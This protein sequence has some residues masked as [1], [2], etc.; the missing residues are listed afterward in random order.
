[1]PTAGERR[2]TSTKGAA[3]EWSF[4]VYVFWFRVR[5]QFF[6]G[7]GFRFFGLRSLFGFRV[8]LGFRILGS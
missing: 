4:R 5:V 6:L 8:F 7:V 1:M 2:S 3:L